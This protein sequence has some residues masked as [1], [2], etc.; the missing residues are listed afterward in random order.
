MSNIEIQRDHD[1]KLHLMVGGNYAA[2]ST[3]LKID[4]INNGLAA[5]VVIP[6]E[7]VRLTEAKNVIP[8]VRPPT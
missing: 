3:V 2:G 5:V 8:F 6:L 1:G 4:Q 7:Y